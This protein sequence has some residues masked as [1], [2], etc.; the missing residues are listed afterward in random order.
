ME[1]SS[2][3][4]TQRSLA[5]PRRLLE[6]VEIWTVSANG[7]KIE[8]AILT[9]GEDKFTIYINI[10][11]QKAGFFLRRVSSADSTHHDANGNSIALGG[12][13]KDKRIIDIGAVDRIQ[14]GQT[15]IVGRG[16][17]RQSDTAMG[18]GS[19]TTDRSFSIIFRGE[20]QLDLMAADPMDRDE[21]LDGLKHIILTYQEAKQKVGSDVLL[22]RYVWLEA[23][24][25]RTA[26]KK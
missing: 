14:R 22:L 6:G 8:P 10:K 9:L 25:V 26:G 1:R 4:H 21:I 17:R 19:G 11:R 12:K 5:V 13:E 16:G 23:D 24:K 18:A 15:S 2:F 7:K 20:R 3:I